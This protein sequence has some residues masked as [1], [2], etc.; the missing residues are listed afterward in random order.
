MLSNNI[1]PELL[2]KT[3]QYIQDA[4]HIVITAHISPDGDAVGSSL[5]LYHLLKSLGKEVT[6]VLPNRF[7][8]FFDWMPASDSIVLLSEL[9]AISIRILQEADLIFCLDF[10]SMSRVDGIKP[11]LEQTK[12][13]LVMID[14]HLDPEPFC[15]VII[16]QPERSSTC[17]LLFRVICGMGWFQ[18]ISYECA[19]CIYTGMMTDTG[20][21]TY[22]SN[23]PEIYII[24][25]Q[26]LSKGLDKDQ[27]Y[28]NV[29]N[30]YSADRTRLLGHCLSNM[31]ILGKE[32]S[33]IMVLTVEDQRRFNFKIGDSEGFV[34][35]PLQIKNIDISVFV[36]EDKDKVKL[37]F[38]S[39][40]P[41]PVNTLAEN[42]GGG[43]HMNA[44]GGE[45]Y[46]SLEET[47][48]KLTEV[49]ATREYPQE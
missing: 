47:N 23:N 7:P 28:R 9:K 18:S 34:N 26:L 5:A 2:N 33:A 3:K 13:K 19:Q 42:F 16:S 36:R 15:D 22:N 39:Q 44:A 11:F 6:V 27:I 14:H 10:N 31:Q 38:R 30:N 21:F 8:S 12:G 41:V 35:T 37:S 1:S 32:R 48:K 17:E 45:S 29:N 20:G 4:Q 49:L 25:N 40:G 46:L 43:G 24:I